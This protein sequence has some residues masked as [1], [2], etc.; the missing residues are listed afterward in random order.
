MDNIDVR[1]GWGF[2]WLDLLMMIVILGLCLGLF[3][4]AILQTR[5]RG[6][7]A[8]CNNSLRT[9]ALAS[10]NAMDTY[11]SLP[12]FDSRA[13]PGNNRWNQSG[14]NYGSPFFHLLPF[15]EQTNLYN[16]GFYPNSAGGTFAASVV[17][18][19]RAAPSNYDPGPPET[20]VDYVV[21]P[22]ETDTVLTQV[23]KV[24]LCPSDPTAQAGSGMAPNG[25]AGSSYACNFLVFGNSNPA[26]VNDPDG[27]GGSGKEGK[28]GA[29]ATIPGS[30]PDGTFNTILFAEKYVSCNDGTTGT[31]WAWANHD[32]AFAPAV[33]ME[34]PWND[35]TKFQLQPPPEK[36]RGQYAQTGHSGGMNVAMADGS[37]RS[38]ATSVSAITYQHAMQPNDGMPL[39]PDW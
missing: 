22:P 12:P 38:V 35:G 18:G 33:A 17:L 19:S 11:G 2:K 1:K 16:G 34:S 4:P 10:H 8:P 27:R 6:Q 36:C 7:R 25:W 23:V 28:W 3:A 21:N 37:V 5:M 9:L 13:I 14:V 32:S 20:I 39:G 29:L 30:F 26:D 15:T 24:L 31:A